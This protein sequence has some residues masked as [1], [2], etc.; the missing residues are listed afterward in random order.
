MQESP[1]PGVAPGLG[2]GEGPTM[3]LLRVGRIIINL[4]HVTDIIQGDSAGSHPES[5]IVNFV[6]G[7][8]HT[9]LGEDA[10]GLRAYLERTVKGAKAPLKDLEAP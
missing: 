10:E 4:D 2:R 9:F 1:R 8:K 5:L 3:N 6:N 7:L